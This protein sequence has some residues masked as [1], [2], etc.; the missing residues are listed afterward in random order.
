MQTPLQIMG[1]DCNRLNTPNK[2]NTTFVFRMAGTFG[3]RGSLFW[4]AER[5]GEWLLFVT[6]GL[7]VLDFVGVV[8]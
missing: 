4:L 6:S 5:R 7:S 3:E 1:T 2:R 8:C